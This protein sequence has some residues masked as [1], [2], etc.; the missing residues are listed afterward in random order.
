MFMSFDLFSLLERD[1]QKILAIFNPPFPLFPTQKSVSRFLTSLS[2]LSKVVSITMNVC[3]SYVT[4]RILYNC[5]FKT[6]FRRVSDLGAQHCSSFVRSD[7]KLHS[8]FLWI[9]KHC[10]TI[11]FFVTLFK[12][13]A[14][15]LFR[16][17][18][19]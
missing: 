3:K 6:G 2:L 14:S 7:G 1:K 13:A 16:T 12:V 4:N 9:L 18:P 5:C 11:S 15:S 17:L 19:F 10:C 8:S